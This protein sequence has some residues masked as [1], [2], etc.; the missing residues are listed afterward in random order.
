MMFLHFRWYAVSRCQQCKLFDQVTDADA[1]FI[2]DPIPEAV[3]E[4]CHV[5]GDTL[6]YMG[7]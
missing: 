4:V 2:T 5:V 1:Q 6:G 7:R 3:M